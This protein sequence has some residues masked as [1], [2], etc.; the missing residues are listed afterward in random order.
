MINILFNSYI[1]IFVFLPIV[2]ILYFISNK[3]NKFNI[4]NI[5]L[6]LS[7]LFFYAYN[8]PMYLIIIISSIIVNYYIGTIIFDMEYTYKPL[9]NKLI[10]KIL[11]KKFLFILG[12]VFNL[13]LLGYFKYYN[14]FL[15]NINSIFNIKIR[16]IQASLPLGISFFTFQQISYLVDSYKSEGKKYKFLEYML[17]VCFFPQLVAGPIVLP[18]EIIPQFKDKKNIFE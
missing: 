17:F 15:E 16:Y 14:F 6:I 10:K 4:A 13:F 12:I 2:L 7:S 5:I 3:Y 1:F 9:E 8:K 11:S 18:Q